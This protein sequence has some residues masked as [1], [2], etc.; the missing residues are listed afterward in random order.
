MA[1]LFISD[2]HLSRERPQAVERTLA[3]LDGPARGADTLYILGDFFDQWLGDDDD[4]PPHR[5]VEA[6]LARLVGAGVPVRVCHGN[7]DFLLGDGFAARTGCELLPEPSVVEVHGIRVLVMHGDSLCTDDHEYQ[8]FRRL[9]RD[10]DTQRRFLALPLAE[11]AAKAAELRLSARARSRLKPEDIMDVN[12]QAV[13]AAMRAHGVLHLVH[14]HTHRPGIHEMTLDDRSAR[15]IVLGD[16]YEKDHL[17]A[18]GPAGCRLGAVREVLTG[19]VE[20]G[21]S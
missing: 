16:W 2:V 9:S 11:R 1:T 10:R 12:P 15:R 19:R 6:A 7:H 3:L 20:E 21:V 8:A 14:G 4:T 18:W 5:E 17:L 13:E